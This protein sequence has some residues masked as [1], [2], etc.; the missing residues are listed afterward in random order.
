M[1]KLKTYLRVWK[2]GSSANK[3]TKKEVPKD[4]SLSSLLTET[5]GEIR[6]NREAGLYQIS[7]ELEK[8]EGSVKESKL[9]EFLVLEE[10][11][12]FIRE[13]FSDEELVNMHKLDVLDVILK[14]LKE[15]KK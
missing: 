2:L 13:L 9:S 11:D 15:D 4:Q 8:K 10:E 12:Q 6:E 7:L 3:G 5:E 1:K 14:A